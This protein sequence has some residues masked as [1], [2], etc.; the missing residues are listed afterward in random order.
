MVNNLKAH[1]S[2]MI[3]GLLLISMMLMGAVII[4]LWHR[5]R[6]HQEVIQTESLLDTVI[7]QK[8]ESEQKNQAFHLSSVFLGKLLQEDI[9]CLQVVSDT[10]VRNLLSGC[11]YNTFSEN[12]LREVRTNNVRVKNSTGFVWNVFSFT[13]STLVIA[14]PFVN[15]L[16]TVEVV[17][18][19]RDLSPLYREF[20][21]NLKL[22]L[23]YLFIN[24]IVFSAIG[25][26]RMM[27]IIHRPI[28]SIT[29]LADSFSDI[30]DFTHFGGKESGDFHGLT[31][32]LNR[33][34]SRIN[35]DNEKL[36]KTVLS[37][38][39]AN[40][41]LTRNRH[42]MVRTEKLASVGRLFAGLAHEIGNPLGVV[43][44]YV[45]MLGEND[46]SVEERRQFS[47]IAQQELQR[48]DKLIRE[49]L[50][51]SRVSLLQAEKISVHQLLRQTVGLVQ[52]EKK[53][54]SI[55]IEEFF[56]AQNDY[57]QAE[58]DRLQQVFLNCLQN[59]IDAILSSER[60]EEGCI[61][62]LSS[63]VIM[64]DKNEMLV[65]EITDNGAG[66]EPRNLENVF[67]PFFT[68]KDIGEGTGL[69]LSVSHMI[70]D[71]LGGEISNYNYFS[72]LRVK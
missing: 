34:I 35:K 47:E 28:E 21:N 72:C 69:G 18:L 7:L 42:E 63:N 32:S 11:D 70:I 10:G 68:T 26:F 24:L 40:E 50:D 53:C 39:N 65:L 27:K 61:H 43:L 19:V 6:L 8:E 67:D 17:R 62:L 49:L 57:V 51:C 12:V 29:R 3:I 16:K 36:K 20:R 71:N 2:I 59:A 45:E 25:F 30:Q 48:I 54:E 5:D 58:P 46:V 66:V 9:V 55:V 23:V 38:E 13:N 1:V 60:K 33:M 22:P 14:A 37:L 64:S 41:E 31:Y 52:I 44:G 56:S 15:S 4:M